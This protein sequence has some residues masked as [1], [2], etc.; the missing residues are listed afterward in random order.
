MSGRIAYYG[1]IVKNGLIL[2]LDAAKLD[3]YPRTGTAWNDIS[4]FRN[5][6][7]LTNFGSQTIFNPDKGGSIVFDGSNDYVEL[8]N[9]LNFEYSTPFSL[10]GWF[11]FNNDADMALIAK[12]DDTVN[13]RGWILRK[14][15]NYQIMFGLVST[16]SLQ[17]QVRIP[18]NTLTTNIWY[19][20]CSTYSGNSLASGCNIYIN[21]VN[22]VLTTASNSLGTNTIITTQNASIGKFSNSIYIPFNGRNAIS[23]IYNRALS[24]SEVLQN[25]NA[26]KTR[27]I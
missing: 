12:E 17:L 26:T 8:G 24:A 2:D 23:Q 9:I 22:Q 18:I 1:G 27:F 3:S 19:Y 15:A 20:I 7:T 10:C 21:G 16:P 13:F 14:L 5:N 4:G 6:G 25:Y 11:Y